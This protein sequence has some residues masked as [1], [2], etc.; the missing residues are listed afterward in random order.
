VNTSVFSTQS[1]STYLHILSRGPAA[2][3]EWK[4]C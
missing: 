4:C 2:S 3:S 1:P